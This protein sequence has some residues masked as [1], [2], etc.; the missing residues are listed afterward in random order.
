MSMLA[1]RMMID[2]VDIVEPRV[3]TARKIPGT[4][5]RKISEEPVE[6]KSER[7][8]DILGSV[9]SADELRQKLST[10][11]RIYEKISPY[12]PESDQEET[13]PVVRG[14]SLRDR[15]QQKADAVGYANVSSPKVMSD[16]PRLV[17]KQLNA[18]S[19]LVE[20]EEPYV[21]NVNGSYLS[22][23]PMATEKP[24]RI[25]VDIPS[26]E[27]SALLEMPSANHGGIQVSFS[28]NNLLVSKLASRMKDPN[29]FPLRG[30][31]VTISGQGLL[32]G[33]NLDIPMKVLVNGST[34]SV[35][36]QSV[37]LNG[38]P[39]EVRIHG[40][41]E[42]PLLEIPKEQVTNLVKNAGKQKLKNA[43]EEKVGDKL[44]GF[45]G[46]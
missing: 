42:A 15:L 13:E 37:D 44:K 40:T 45:F 28:Q 22:D 29:Q 21:I 11:K 32:A 41:L 12:L 38:V 35:L 14:L 7:D 46:G 25:Q 31:S 19:L 30:G 39:L 8:F 33:D 2:S 26:K 1:K 6:K 3:G 10:V 17:I 16:F 36:G 4:L 18:E 5:I 34:L 23:N 20:G 27:L 43:V 24:G 9:K